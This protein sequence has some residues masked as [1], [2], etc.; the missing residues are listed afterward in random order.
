MLRRGGRG[1]CTAVRV[2][3]RPRRRRPASPR[4]HHPSRV[5]RW[6]AI[7]SATGTA[8]GGPE[9]EVTVM[10][11]VTITAT[12]SPGSATGCPGGSS[13]TVVRRSSVLQA[14]GHTTS[15]GTTSPGARAVSV[16][17][18]PPGCAGS[19]VSQAM[20]NCSAVS[21][22]RQLL[23]TQV[24][25]PVARCRPGEA[26]IG[27]GYRTRGGGGGARRLPRRRSDPTQS[28][29]PTRDHVR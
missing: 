6:S 17:R 5:E 12:V 16:A 13:T 15:W 4:L 18:S 24:G 11:P 3:P 7:L 29:T 26:D 8:A 21:L 1:S 9:S 10:M 20:T 25:D 2:M 28:A 22:G 14:A 27:G 23:G 19:V